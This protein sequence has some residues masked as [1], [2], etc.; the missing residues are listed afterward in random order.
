MEDNEEVTDAGGAVKAASGDIYQLAYDTRKGYVPYN[1]N[2][3]NQDRHVI[4]FDL[5]GNSALSMFGVMDGHGEFGHDVSSMVQK[6]LYKLLED[7]Q[8]LSDNPHDS[9][10]SAVANMEAELR[11]SSINIAFSGTTV[12]KQ[13]RADTA[14]IRI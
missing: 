10:K 14:L 4:Q 2:K 8:E 5:Q 12:S 9:I 6:R 11:A 7:E 1:R 3:V 13:A